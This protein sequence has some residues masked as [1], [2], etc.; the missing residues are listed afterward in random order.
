VK[1]PTKVITPLLA[2]FAVTVLKFASTLPKG[3]VAPGA[4]NATLLNKSP[5]TANAE[6]TVRRFIFIY[7]KYFFR[8]FYHNPKKIT[9]K[10][11]KHKTLSYA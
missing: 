6:N 5:V 11:A 7:I 1:V 4:A 9:K 2:L 3:G 8:Q 10:C